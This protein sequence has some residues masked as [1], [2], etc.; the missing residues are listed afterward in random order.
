MVTLATLDS[1]LDRV[2]GIQLVDPAVA[3]TI[4]NP[5]AVDE[6]VGDFVSYSAAIEDE[7]GVSGGVAE[8]MLPNMDAQLRRF[9]DLWY[10]QEA[11]H[12]EG[13]LRLLEN[14][15]R[16][17]MPA[18]EHKILPEYRAVGFA[19]KHSA[20]VHTVM[21]AFLMG[22]M[23]LGEE[24]TLRFY[25]FIRN[26]LREVGEHA[27]GGMFA[28]YAAH[29]VHHREYQ[30]HRARYAHAR[31]GDG[32]RS[33]IPGFL[34][35][36]KY[37]PVG[38][39]DYDSERAVMFGRIINELGDDDGAAVATSVLEVAHRMFPNISPQSDFM[40]RAYAQTLAAAQQL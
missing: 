37:L 23:A 5:S 30:E 19:A 27:L 38:V 12:G 31:I 13:Q 6:A 28:H 1:R 21:E 29:E 22:Y 3:D 40:T 2:E 16:E 39:S 32:W 15:G 24:E 11:S 7:V 20:A 25:P 36:R 8:L 35:E 26:R 18:N 17:P 14:I 10:V 4:I 33:N 9:F 34:L